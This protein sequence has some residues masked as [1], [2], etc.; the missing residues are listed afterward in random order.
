MGPGRQSFPIRLLARSW[1]SPRVFECALE[2]PEGFSFLPGQSIRLRHGGVERDY[3]IASGMGEG[4][5]LI[6]VRLIEGGAL[7]P[8]LASAEPG[9]AMLLEGPRGFFFHRESPRPCVLVATG[10]GVAPFRSMAASGLKAYTLLHGV[11]GPEEL[12]YRGSLEP[13]AGRYVACISGQGG[14]A[15]LP[16]AYEGRVTAWVGERLERREHDFYL[17]GHRGMV[18]DLSL[19]IDAEF[20]GSMLYA[21]IFD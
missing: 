10:T 19:M 18:R 11:R 17:C 5:L 6:C 4:E 14:A 7:S 1:L 9:E 20:P 8:A 2:R 15:A 12:C 3:S 13:G 21:E 16:G